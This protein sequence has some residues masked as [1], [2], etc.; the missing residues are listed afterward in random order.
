MTV[1]PQ[2]AFFSVEVLRILACQGNSYLSA[3]SPPT[4]RPEFSIR[5]LSLYSLLTLPQLGTG[6]IMFRHWPAMIFWFWLH[7]SG[8]VIIGVVDVVVVVVVVV[9]GE[10]VVVVG[11]TVVLG[12][13]VVV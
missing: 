8:M 9:V 4:T 7:G 11:G 1:P 2:N 12:F 3:F 13:R 5:L 10:V 6:L